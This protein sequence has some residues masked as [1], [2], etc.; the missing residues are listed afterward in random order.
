MKIKHLLEYVFPTIQHVN[1][2]ATIHP[3]S[4]AGKPKDVK[5]AGEG[6]FA[7][8]WHNPQKTPHDIRKISTGADRHELDGF[9]FYMLALAKHSDN[10]NPYFPRFRAIKIYTDRH[11]EL[12]VG[13]GNRPT[14]YITYS[15]QIEK[16]TTLS[17]LS[18]T[19]KRSILFRLFGDRQHRGKNANNF[20]E[21]QLSNH[22][23]YGY[24]ILGII[25]M[26]L[27]TN[28]GIIK[29]IV[30]EDF[31]NAI[32][33]LK[34]IH[35]YESVEYDIHDDNIMIRRTPYG[36]QLVFSDPFSYQKGDARLR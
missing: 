36:P 28:L 8:V 12:G 35:E 30:D 29:L 14:D 31:K 26:S 11:G 10:T 7:N 20:I 2:N 27:S 34:E 16:L 5:H 21:K 4:A 24:K 9:Y 19:E 33:F 15:A 3:G 13:T 23:P 18:K 6:S 17:S 22:Q 1:V 32:K 25:R